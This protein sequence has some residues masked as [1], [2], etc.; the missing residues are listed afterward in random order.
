MLAAVGGKNARDHTRNL[1]SNCDKSSSPSSCEDDQQLL[2]RYC[3][4]ISIGL[5]DK[6]EAAAIL[7][8]SL[9]DDLLPPYQ[10]GL[11]GIPRQ[12]TPLHVII[13]RIAEEAAI[14]YKARGF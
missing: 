14:D 7:V 10:G 6:A 12:R 4:K 3:N 13:M 11:G 8:S 9:G 5:Q 2:Y 1:M